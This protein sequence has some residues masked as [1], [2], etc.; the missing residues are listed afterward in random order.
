MSPGISDERMKLYVYQKKMPEAEILGLRDRLMGVAEEGERIVVQ[1]IA[2]DDLITTVKDAKSL[3]AIA[4][5]NGMP[6]RVAARA[7]QRAAESAE[8]AKEV[9]KGRA[10]KKKSLDE[11]RRP[12]RPYFA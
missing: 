7:K 9:D 2:F 6:A 8:K 11:A 1:V 10:S 12:P 4:L 3:A 5:Y